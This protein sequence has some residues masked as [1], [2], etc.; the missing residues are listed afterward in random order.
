MLC[1]YLVR[2]NRPAKCCSGEHETLFNLLGSL[3]TDIIPSLWFQCAAINIVF[4]IMLYLLLNPL[5]L[6]LSLMC[7]LEF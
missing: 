1:F 2:F 4:V 5:S 3:E 6:F 7:A